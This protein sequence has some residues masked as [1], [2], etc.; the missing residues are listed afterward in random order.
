MR[1]PCRDELLLYLTVVAT[2]SSETT[3]RLIGWAG[4]DAGRLSGSAPG[5]GREPTTDSPGDRRGLRWEPPA[6][7]IARYVTRDVEY[8]G[9][10]VPKGSAMLMLFGAANRD[11]RRFPETMTSSTSTGNNA[12][13]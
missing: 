6:L 11:Q 3:T 2:A 9:Q 12:R 7:H 4:K 13:T 1:K 10:T 5:T 8:Y